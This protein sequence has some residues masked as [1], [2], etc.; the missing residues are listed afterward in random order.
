MLVF[1]IFYDT[2]HCLSTFSIRN[3]YHSHGLVYLLHAILYKLGL[4]SGSYPIR[5]HIAFR[6]QLLQVRGGK[7]NW[8]ELVWPVA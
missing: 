4:S 1:V 5:G 6:Y 2:V 8:L 3:A 7:M